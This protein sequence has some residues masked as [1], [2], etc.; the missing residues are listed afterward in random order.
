LCLAK[1]RSTGRAV[2]VAGD[3]IQPTV[4]VEIGKEYDGFGWRALSGLLV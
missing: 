3:D 1:T 4:A 2:A